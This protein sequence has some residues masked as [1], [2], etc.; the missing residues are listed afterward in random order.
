M[1][2]NQ[3]TSHVA[4]LSLAGA[5]NRSEPTNKCISDDRF[6]RLMGEAAWA[7]LPHSIRCR[8]GKRLSSGA[9]V[10]YQGEVTDMKMNRAGRLLAFLARAIG[11]PLPYDSSSVGR[12]AV[13]VVTE[14]AATNGQFWIRQYG[15]E[16]GFPQTVCSSKRFAGPT[17]LE[18]YIG[19]GIGM[20]LRL[21]ATPHALW[22][23][24]A[25]Y[26]INIG[27]LR[28]AL[29]RLF[30][31]GELVVGHEELGEG[32]FRFS[33]DLRHPFFG[34]MISQSARFRDADIVRGSHERLH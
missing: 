16:K 5:S 32:K 22:F 34:T 12:A 20:A 17:G 9:S 3:K 8:F 19:Y 30:S 26:F 24:S 14:D 4:A 2:D 1:Y 33:L 23:I 6:R 29:P 10:A 27:R 25:G 13:V 11:A 15:K 7:R 28:L 31:P 21:E 18:E